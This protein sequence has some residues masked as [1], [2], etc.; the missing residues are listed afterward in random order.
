MTGFLIAVL[1]KANILHWNDKLVDVFP[2]IGDPASRAQN[3]IRSD[4]L[5]VTVEQI[6]SQQSFW[7]AGSGSGFE[8]EWLNKPGLM[9]RRFQ[10]P[11]MSMQFPPAFPPG[12]GR[13]YGGAPTICGALAE[14]R[15]ARLS[16]NCTTN[17]SSSRRG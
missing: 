1:A 16:K 5:N 15:P 8:Q 14:R 11:I 9:Y 4:Y 10:Y 2:E 3:G 7:F 12:T 13:G 6:M 17:A